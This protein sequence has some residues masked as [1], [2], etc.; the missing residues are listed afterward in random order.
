M[1][2]AAWNKDVLRRAGYRAAVSTLWGVNNPST[3]VM[4]LRRGQPWETDPA[5]FAAKLDWYQ[6]SDL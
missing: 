6:W 1:D 5:M 3:D 2:F 4:E